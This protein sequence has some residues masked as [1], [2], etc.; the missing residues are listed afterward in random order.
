MNFSIPVKVIVLPVCVLLMNLFFMMFASLVVE[1]PL[2]GL[3]MF[4]E[5][6]FVNVFS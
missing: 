1:S 5:E 2:S 4:I 3:L 6:L